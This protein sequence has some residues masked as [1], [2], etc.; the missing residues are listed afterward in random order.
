MYRKRNWTET[1]LKLNTANLHELLFKCIRMALSIKRSATT[2]LLTVTFYICVL[3]GYPICIIKAFSLTEVDSKCSGQPQCMG[4][5]LHLFSSKFTYKL[6]MV[7]R[8]L[9]STKLIHTWDCDLLFWS[10]HLNCI[11]RVKLHMH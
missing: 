10:E 4:P 6:L 3:E 7:F 11:L 2:T 1:A 9:L 8:Y 5:P